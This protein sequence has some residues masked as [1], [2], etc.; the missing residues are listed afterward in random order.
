MRVIIRVSLYTVNNYFKDFDLLEYRFIVVNNIDNP[1][2]L[3]WGF[4]QTKAVGVIDLGGKKF[5]D[6]E[7]IGK[8]L[9]HYLDDC[10]SVPDGI[11]INKPNSIESWL[12][13]MR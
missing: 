5:R 3:V 7:T 6:P 11:S 1:I 12:E 9:R 4:R 10:P 13:N 8:E 2:P